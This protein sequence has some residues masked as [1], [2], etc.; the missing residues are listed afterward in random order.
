[1]TPSQR[2]TVEAH[3][4]DAQREV[5]EEALEAVGLP[6]RAWPHAAGR[7]RRP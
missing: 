4:T 7:S 5:L 3:L 1:M 2:E 6:F